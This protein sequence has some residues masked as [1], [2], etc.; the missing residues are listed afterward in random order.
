MEGKKVAKT[1]GK[2]GLLFFVVLIAGF[3]IIPS[4]EVI[5]GFRIALLVAIASVLVYLFA[6]K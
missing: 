3:I 2:A 1:V 5:S 6:R 4:W